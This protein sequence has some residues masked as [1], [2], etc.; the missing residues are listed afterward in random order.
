MVQQVSQLLQKPHLAWSCGIF[1]G[2]H[3]WIKKLYNVEN[4]A[5]SAL[6]KGLGGYVELTN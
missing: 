4:M 1:A 3:C 6:G 5:R 2:R